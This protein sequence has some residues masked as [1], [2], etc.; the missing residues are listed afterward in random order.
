MN[1][2][3]IINEIRQKTDIVDII[4]EYI[5]L[6][7]RGKNYFG[8]CPF[9][10]DT[11]PSMSVSREKQIYTC[12]SCHATGNVFTFLM[13]YEHKEFQE[14]LHDLSERTGVKLLGYQP[15]KIIS[16]Y[17]EWYK[18]Y[19]LATKY[20]QNNLASSIGKEARA[21]LEERKITDEIMKEFEIGWAQEE[22]ASLT[23]LLVKKGYSLDLLNKTGITTND[24]D[25]YHNRLMFPLHDLNGKII[26]FS[27][28]IIHGNQNKYLNTKETA[29]FKKGRLLYHYHIAKEEARKEKCVIIMEGFMDVIRASS[30][31]V[32]NTVATMGTALTKEHIQDIKRLSPNIIL[33]F[34]GDDAGYKATLAAGKLFN[35]YKIEPSR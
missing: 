26:G 16:K 12:F 11:N 21:Y 27:G 34:D 30:I 32:K 33:C 22:R 15:K 18:I 8:V 17:D 5:P 2:Q 13:N 4:G 28:R 10:D 3:D 1:Q 29:I 25:I 35:E 31:G 20:Y 23:N 19:E 7:A 9:H 6:T 14:V 24:Y